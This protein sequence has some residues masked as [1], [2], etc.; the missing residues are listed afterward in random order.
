MII[1]QPGYY[2]LLKA[3]V[4]RGPNSIHSIPQKTI[5]KITQINPRNRQIIG[6]SLPDWI[7]WDVPAEKIDIEE[8]Y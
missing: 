7:Y 1:C 2:R 5:M 4:V 6:P 8:E 3:I